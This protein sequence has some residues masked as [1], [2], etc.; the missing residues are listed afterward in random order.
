[1][2][3]KRN[4][5]CGERAYSYPSSDSARSEGPGTAKSSVV[6]VRDVTLIIAKKVN[7]VMSPPASSARRN[8][9]DG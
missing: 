2:E 7:P 6:V 3:Q 5:T 1:M 9:T 4:V 8:G